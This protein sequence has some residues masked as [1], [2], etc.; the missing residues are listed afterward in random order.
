MAKLSQSI[1]INVVILN[2]EYQMRILICLLCLMSVIGGAQSLSN[3]NLAHLY[4]SENELEFMSLMVKREGKMVISYSLRARETKSPEM[5][6]MQW[7]ERDSYSQRQGNM[8]RT[9][10]VLMS[11]NETKAGE[12]EVNVKNESWLLLLTITKVTDSKKWAY[13]F[14][15][16]KNYPVIGYAVAGSQKVFTPYLRTAT[17][18]QFVGPKDKETLYAYYYNDIFNSAFPPFSKSTAGADPLML[19]DST[20]TIDNGATISLDKEGLYLFQ[21]D[22]SSA[23]GFAFRV[24]AGTFPRYSRIEDLTEPLVFICTKDEFDKLLAANGDKVEFDKTILG[25]TR[26]KDRAR[27][28]MKSYYNQVE[29]ANHYFTSY[30]EGWKTDMGMIFI[31]FGLPDEV[32]KTGQ[33][34]IWYYKNTRTKFVFVKKGSVYDP[35]YWVLMRDDRFSE[36]WYNTIDL[37]RKSRF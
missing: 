31:I 30:K 11:G 8:V 1:R 5:F 37:W 9:D 21:S 13:P 6:L 14:L 7:E 25:I 33:N 10:S 12:V 26:D 35:D 16:E 17:A 36:V 27:R 18:Y 24:S 3:E 20:F 19:H 34:E 15:I 4:N 23:E 28:F 29:L 2:L 22:T 32:R